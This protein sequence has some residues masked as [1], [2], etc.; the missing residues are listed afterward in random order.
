MLLFMGQNEERNHWTR[1]DAFQGET[2]K[3]DAEITEDDIKKLADR[4][5]TLRVTNFGGNMP[6]ECKVTIA[7]EEP[8]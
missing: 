2:L 4:Y 6:A 7:I 1:I 3:I 8:Q 5:W